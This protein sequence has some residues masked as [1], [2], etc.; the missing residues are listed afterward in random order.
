M[1]LWE[2]YDIAPYVYVGDDTI[3]GSRGKA[4][5]IAALWPHL[6]YGFGGAYTTSAQHC[7]E[8]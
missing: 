5:L 8:R 3:V 4:L 2:L 7:C 1:S 6:V